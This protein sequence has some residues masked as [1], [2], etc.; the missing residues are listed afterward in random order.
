MNRARSEQ[1]TKRVSYTSVRFANRNPSPQ[2]RRRLDDA[3]LTPPVARSRARLPPCRPERRPL[4]TAHRDRP[5][6]RKKDRSCQLNARPAWRG[7][8]T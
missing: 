2:L 6:A 5:R 3:N 1:G 8:Q 7:K 4:R